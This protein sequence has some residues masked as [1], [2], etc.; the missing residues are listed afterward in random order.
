M[1]A[2]KKSAGAGC[3]ADLPGCLSSAL[4]CIVGDETAST[5]ARTAAPADAAGA[6]V[7]RSTQIL[8]I[9]SSPSTECGRLG[10]LVW[11]GFLRFL[12]AVYAAY[13]SE[14]RLFGFRSAATLKSLMLRTGVQSAAG[15]SATST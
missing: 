12:E 15:S 8:R 2:T 9:E 7:R 5:K 13:H 10:G 1:E 4:P 14:G 6:K 3:V 11:F